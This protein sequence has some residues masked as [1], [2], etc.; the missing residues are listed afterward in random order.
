M[1]KE[2]QKGMEL[3]RMFER[4]ESLVDKMRAKY[5]PELNIEGFE[6]ALTTNI[7]E[8]ALVI[9]K[10]CVQQREREVLEDARI[11]KAFAV[12]FDCDKYPNHIAQSGNSDQ[13]C[14]IY[15]T[16]KDARA[17]QWY[18]FGKKL[19]VPIDILLPKNNHPKKQT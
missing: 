7:A 11:T 10:E 13:H 14:G 5:P 3:E 18:G 8:I 19:I 2:K 1:T 15:M 12:M 17:S 16:K 4:V 9:E 6:P